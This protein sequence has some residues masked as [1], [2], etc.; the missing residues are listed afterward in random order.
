ME[1][2]GV[3]GGNHRPTASNCMMKLFTHTHTQS[4]GTGFGVPEPGIPEPGE[5]G[6]R[7][8]EPG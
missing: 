5:K 1:E 8:P 3:P 6:T 4:G 2:T 7:V